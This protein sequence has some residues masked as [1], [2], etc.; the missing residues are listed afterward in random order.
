MPPKTNGQKKFNVEEFCESLIA[1][2]YFHRIKAT[3]QREV[4]RSVGEHVLNITNKNLRKCQYRALINK[5]K[6]FYYNNEKEIDHYFS[7]KFKG[8]NL[9]FAKIFQLDFNYF[10]IF[11]IDN[12]FNY[13][14]KDNIYEKF[15]TINYLCILSE[16]SKYVRAHGQY[17]II[18]FKCTFLNCPATYTLTL[19]NSVYDKNST[20]IFT[21][22][23]EGQVLHQKEVN[24]AAFIN[25]DV[26]LELGK[27][28]T[29]EFACNV[30]YGLVK[31]H[32]QKCVENNLGVQSDI[33][34]IAPSKEAL[35]KIRQDENKKS[36]LDPDNFM[37]VVKFK[38]LQFSTNI[39]FIREISN[40]PLKILLIT[41]L[42]KL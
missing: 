17:V 30:Y 7:T 35:R 4:L 20:L 37:D 2:N 9:N 15:S 6:M 8:P 24:K 34:K 11:N 25:K 28:L 18:Q 40:T 42:L 16:T 26:R 38:D 19:K 13:I 32:K 29:Q 41:R 33:K 36:K 12:A 3:P 14:L 22:E 21:V 31:E 10:D 23:Q 5:M 1:T 27:K 39:V